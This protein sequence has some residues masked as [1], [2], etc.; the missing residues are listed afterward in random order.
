MT[1]PADDFADHLIKNG[2]K[3]EELFVGQ[4]PDKPL[5]CITLYDT[6]GMAVQDN[7]PLDV[8]TLQVRVRNIEYKDGYNRA[9]EVKQILQSMSEVEL[10]GNRYYGTWL[11]SD[12]MFIGPS[13]SGKESIFTLNLRTQRQLSNPGNRN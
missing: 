5:N 1:S 13:E 8:N 4:E 10:N 6:G 7:A 9:H 11:T 12:V 3:E 2:F